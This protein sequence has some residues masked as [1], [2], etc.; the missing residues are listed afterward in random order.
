MGVSY[1]EVLKK[2]LTKTHVKE[3]KQEKK[4]KEQ[5]Y[6]NIQSKLISNIHSYS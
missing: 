2:K 4:K 6:E 5:T 3:E 1:L